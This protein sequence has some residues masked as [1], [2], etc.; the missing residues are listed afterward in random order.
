MIDLVQYLYVGVVC[1]IRGLKWGELQ[2]LRCL[3]PWLRRRATLI[4]ESV[5][6]VFHYP[7][8]DKRCVDKPVVSKGEEERIL[9]G[10]GYDRLCHVK[11]LD[12]EYFVRVANGGELDLG[13]FLSLFF[14]LVKILICGL[15]RRDPGMWRSV[16]GP[17][18]GR[19]R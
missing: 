12:S 19:V 14:K 13:D 11:V 5:G 15:F 3:K 16:H 18:C 17:N 6:V 7:N 8:E 1:V 2:V 4:G 9:G 10:C